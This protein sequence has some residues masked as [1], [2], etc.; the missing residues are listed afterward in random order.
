VLSAHL[1][2]LGDVL[3]KGIVHRLR[4]TLLLFV[5]G[6]SLLR[7]MS[8]P[9]NSRRALLLLLFGGLLDLRLVE[10]AVNRCDRVFNGGCALLHCQN[11]PAGV[12]GLSDRR[13]RVF[14]LRCQIGPPAFQGGDPIRCG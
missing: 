14:K 5:Q 6:G 7:Q 1:A 12:Q 2:H 8:Q 4:Y 9:I 13:A 10:R 11:I 3:F